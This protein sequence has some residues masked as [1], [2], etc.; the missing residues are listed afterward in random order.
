MGT[1]KAPG[2]KA[3][4]PGALCSSASAKQPPSVIAREAK[5]GFG[6]C[7][8]KESLLCVCN[9]AI[10]MALVLQALDAP[11]KGELLELLRGG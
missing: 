11:V 8:E 6:S 7:Y 2:P 4:A 5:R 1:E 3:A 10:N 9:G